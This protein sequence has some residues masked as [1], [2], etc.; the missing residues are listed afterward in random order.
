MLHGKTEDTYFTIKEKN[1]VGIVAVSNKRKY[2]KE[3][4]AIHN[5]A[6]VAL[7][8]QRAYEDRLATLK[9][10]QKEKKG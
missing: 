2:K 9:H 1:N 5:A 7:D 8:A 4:V 3:I 10:R 6:N